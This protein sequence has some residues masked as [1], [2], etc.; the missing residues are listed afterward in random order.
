[1]EDGY[2]KL[3][4]LIES[5]K[6][7]VEI[8]KDKVE[9]LELSQSVTNGQVRLIKDQQSVINKKLDDINEVQED[10]LLPSV[11]TIENEIKV[12]GDMYKLNNDNMKKLEKRMET[13]EDNAGVE[14][15]PEL[16]LT[17]VQ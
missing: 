15:P 14:P 8:T 17:E 2:Q 1:M 10:K 13:L 16:T 7:I 9:K 5:I 4:K 3:E 6:E 11:V 12:Y